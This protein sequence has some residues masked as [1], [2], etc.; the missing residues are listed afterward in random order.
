MGTSPNPLG[1]AVDYLR[2]LP[3]A[4]SVGVPVLAL[5]AVFLA[6]SLLSYVGIVSVV[7]VAGE[8]PSG[9][10]D[11]T[12]P[13]NL[14]PFFTA[15][16]AVSSCSVA[17]HLLTDADYDLYVTNGR[18][19]PVTLDC[20]VTEAVMRTRIGHMVTVSSELPNAT[21][22]PYVIT[23]AFYAERLPYAALAIPGAVLAIGTTIWIAITFLTRGTE[24]LVAE[25]RERSPGRKGK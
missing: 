18:L 20:N 17:F 24:K 19:P 5:G 3:R 8:A 4:Y 15:T 1:K 2:R 7:N 25:F 6:A 9:R 11:R 23:A 10:A 16:L 14:T 12:V 13:L 22:V 21:G